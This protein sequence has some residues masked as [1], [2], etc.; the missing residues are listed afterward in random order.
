MT[1]AATL[2]VGLPQASAEPITAARTLHGLTATHAPRRGVA[3]ATYTSLQTRAF[4]IEGS[5]YHWEF[6]A[7]QYRPGP[8]VPPDDPTL[9]IVGFRTARSG[10][11]QQ[12][13]TW[14]IDLADGSLT[15]DR[16]LRHVG[17]DTG[18]IPG[19]GAIFM[20]LEHLGAMTF[21]TYRCPKTGEILSKTSARKGVLRGSMTFLPGYSDPQMPDDVNITHVRAR[22]ER[23]KYTGNECPYGNTCDRGKTLSAIELG[24]GGGD[25]VQAGTSGPFQALAFQQ[26]EIVGVAIVDHFVLAYGDVDVLQV[27]PTTVAVLSDIAAPFI[28]S[29]GTMSWT[30]GTRDVHQTRRCRTTTWQLISPTG[31]FNLHLDSGDRTLAAPTDAQYRVVKRR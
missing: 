25:L 17:L 20:D 9:R 24:P 23:T 29:G 13:H 15:F 26:Q 22:I 2:A 30:K 4:T 10:T 11:L 3:G 8:G 19:Y 31:S 28:E 5:P 1:I 16:N 27:S 18:L 14:D 12:A 6:E 7:S 21:S